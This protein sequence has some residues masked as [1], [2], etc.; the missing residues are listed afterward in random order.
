MELLTEQQQQQVGEKGDE[1][2]TQASGWS[3]QMLETQLNR[4]VLS[5]NTEKRAKCTVT[6]DTVRD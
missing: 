3:M 2:S 5:E 4:A 6:K 1:A